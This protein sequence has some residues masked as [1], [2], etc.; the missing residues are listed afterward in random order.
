MRYKRRFRDVNSDTTWEYSCHLLGEAPTGGTS[1]HVDSRCDGRMNCC[2]SNS[3]RS[4]SLPLFKR[5]NASRRHW[6]QLAVGGRESSP[7]RGSGVRTQRMK[8][9]AAHI[10]LFSA[11][12]RATKCSPLQEA[13]CYLQISRSTDLDETLY[14]QYTLKV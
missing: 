5:R 8:I 10:L 3:T 13:G 6:H 2:D 9:K 4:L 11:G 1:S 12:F 7:R 14:L